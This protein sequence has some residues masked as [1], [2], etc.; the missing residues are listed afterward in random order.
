MEIVLLGI[1]VQRVRM[2]YS[3][4]I[5]FVVQGIFVKLEV[6][7][8][9]DVYQECISFIGL[10]LYVKYVQQVFIVKYLVRFIIYLL[11]F[12]LKIRK[13]LLKEYI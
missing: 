12:I 1:I 8:R 5:M 6:G 4:L 11:Y 13:I 7:M 3:L 10:D 2:Y 9:Q